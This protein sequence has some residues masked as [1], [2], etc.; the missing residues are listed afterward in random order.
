MRALLGRVRAEALER[1]YP[2][3]TVYAPSN[4][5]VMEVIRTSSGRI[6]DQESYDGTVSMYHIPDLGRFLQAILPGTG[7]P[8]RRVRGPVASGAGNLRWTTSDG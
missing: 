7:P 6:I 5:P 3:V 8:R 4:H 2:E 1:A